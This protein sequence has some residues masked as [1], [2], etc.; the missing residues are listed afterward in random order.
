MSRTRNRCSVSFHPPVSRF[1]SRF[2][3][4]QPTEP[5]PAHF[6]I[7]KS[8]LVEQMPKWAASSSPS[9]LFGGAPILCDGQTAR[10]S[11]KMVHHPVTWRWLRTRDVA[12]RTE[13]RATR[14]PSRRIDIWPT[15]RAVTPSSTRVDEQKGWNGPPV[16][17]GQNHSLTKLTGKEGACRCT[18]SSGIGA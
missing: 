8:V 4:V 6:Y 18:A 15:S 7:P 9:V 16:G 2:N 11:R 3:L 10:E 13:L 14:N 5:E 17:H 12:S 1:N